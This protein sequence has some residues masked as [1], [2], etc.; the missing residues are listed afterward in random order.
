M[1]TAQLIPD[2][3]HAEQHSAAYDLFRSLSRDCAEL[4]VW[5]RVAQFALH[6]ALVSH[7]HLEFP[8]DDDWA[9][10][11][12]A[13]L[14]ACTMDFGAAGDDELLGDVV[15]GL[16][17]L[18][19][20]RQEMD[21]PVFRIR[22]LDDAAT[23]SDDVTITQLRVEVENKLPLEVEVKDVWLDLDSSSFGTV[24]YSS[25]PVALSTGKQAVTLSCSVRP[26]RRVA[27]S[28]RQY[29]VLQ[30]SVKVL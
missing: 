15:A 2:D 17:E 6:G 20:P 24:T 10:L 13:Y 8:R 5:D 28:R 11:V 21:S 14:R 18:P 22:V 7:R 3:R 26:V 9:H 12:I 25:G 19:E 1:S 23:I 27:D 29:P 16:K 30:L 4:H